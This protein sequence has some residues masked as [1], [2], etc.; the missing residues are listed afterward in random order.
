MTCY[1]LAIAHLLIHANDI[2]GAIDGVN[3]YIEKVEGCGDL[4]EHWNKALTAK[5]EKDLLPATEMIGFI[6]IAFSYAFYYLKN[7]YTY[8][9]AI[10]AMLLCGGD[11]DTNAAI[12]GGL[13]GACYGIDSIPVEWRDAVLGFKYARSSKKLFDIKGK[14]SF[15]QKVKTLFIYDEC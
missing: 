7:E 1:N 6:L 2:K 5:T 3:F 4:K 11:T 10:K 15:K 9:E 12:V 13:L 8:E 14:G